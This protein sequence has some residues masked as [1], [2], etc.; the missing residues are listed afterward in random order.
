MTDQYLRTI[1][2]VVGGSQAPGVAVNPNAAIDLS[3]LHIT[4]EV[5]NATTQ[6]PKFA[7]ILI[8]NLADKTANAIQ[9]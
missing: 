4:F 2:L 9:N 5:R 6:S 3:Q 7:K 8:Y 1:K